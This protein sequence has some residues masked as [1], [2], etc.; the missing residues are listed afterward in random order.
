MAAEAVAMITTDHT[1]ITTN[2]QKQITSNGCENELCSESPYKKRCS[3]KFFSSETNDDL[4]INLNRS[5]DV[6]EAARLLM[7][8]SS[9]IICG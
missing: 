9:D 8:L 1:R 6:K 3:S 7:A 5:S 4:G 2:K